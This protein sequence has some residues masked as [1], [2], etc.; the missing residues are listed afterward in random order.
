LS[1]RNGD[2]RSYSRMSGRVSNQTPGHSV[3][4]FG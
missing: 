2:G 3:L 4:V 1:G